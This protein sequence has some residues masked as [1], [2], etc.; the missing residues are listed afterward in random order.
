[1]DVT[2][3]L[4]APKEKLDATVTHGR[5]R[6]G[7]FFLVDGDDD[8]SAGGKFSA[9]KLLPAEGTLVSRVVSTATDRHSTALLRD[10]SCRLR[11]QALIWQ[12]HG[13]ADAPAECFFREIGGLVGVVR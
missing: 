2:F 13:R 10:E 9:G 12:T 7:F 1:V 8:D 3:I 5:R 11:M 6:I 4:H